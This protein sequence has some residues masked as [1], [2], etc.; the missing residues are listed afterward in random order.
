MGKFSHEHGNRHGKRGQRG[1]AKHTERAGRYWLY[2]AHAVAAALS[3]PERKIKRILSLRDAAFAY[4]LES[5][6][7]RPEILEQKE[8]V[9]LLGPEAVHQGVAVEVEPLEQPFLDE[10]IRGDRP[11]LVLDQVTDPHN[12]GA[13]LRSAAAFDAGAVIVPKDHSAPETAVMAKSASGALDIVPLVTVTNLATALREIQEA[14][15]WVA[16]LSGHASMTVSEAKLHRKTCLVLG[17]EG[18]GMRRLTE[19]SCDVLVKLPMS[20]RM[21]SLNVSNAAAIALFCLYR[22]M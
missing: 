13:I 21:E 2:G 16:G 17:A 10:V 6:H 3:N 15:Y 7:P 5:Y 11:L 22:G 4:P 8:L 18:K 19:E 14:G 1:T 9:L 20:E 12:V